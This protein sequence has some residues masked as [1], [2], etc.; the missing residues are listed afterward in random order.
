MTI[1][2]MIYRQRIYEATRR[3]MSSATSMREHWQ[4]GLDDARRTLQRRD[5]LSMPEEGMASS[6]ATRTA[7]GIIDPTNPAASSM[8]GKG[9]GFPI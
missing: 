6:F 3:T 1:M 4:S 8:S 5:R 7:N 2:Q 9:A